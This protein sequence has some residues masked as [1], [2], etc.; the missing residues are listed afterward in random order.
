MSGSSPK[1]DQ[2]PPSDSPEKLAGDSSKQTG[3][4]KRVLLTLVKF[5]IPV[6]IIAFLVSNVD[7]AQW[8]AL[9]EH[10]KNYGLLAA[11][12]LV[13]I[14]AMA[15]SFARWCLLVRCQ[16]ID[17]T[18]LEAQR[19]GAICFLL[20]FVSAGSVGGDL[21]KAIFLA[22][23]RPGKRIEAVASVLVDRGAGLYA[24]LL[25][26]AVA[27][28]F[29]KAPTDAEYMD[30]VKTGTAVLVG[31]GT[32]V[33]V[34][35]VF[36]GRIVD[37]LIRWGST[38]P[39][40]GGLVDKIGPPLRM[41]HHHKFAFAMS[42]VMSLGVQSMLVISM[43]FVAKGLYAEPPTLAEHFVIV[44]IG[45]LMSALPLTPAGVGVLE[46][47]IDK[48]YEVVPAEPTVA[49]GT[50]V[51][52]VFELVKVVMGVIGTIFYWTA[53]EEVRESLEE[54]EEEA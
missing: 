11:A 19:L 42:I 23:R 45:M 48:L 26:V 7:E 46:A 24:L 44:P 5:A 15:L 33:L 4:S 1:N 2:P 16:G 43:F 40:V 14:G 36:G 31:L 18:M 38:L 52:L 17:L 41:F 53:N 3:R 54:A 34:I 8:A 25:L 29:L 50:L 51:A 35:L 27:L 12:L 49:S 39:L 47:T 30:Q 22:R 10:D 9:A 21:F 28:L 20:S 6:G 13:S 37:Q 32:V